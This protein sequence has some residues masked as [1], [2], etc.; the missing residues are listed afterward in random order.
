MDRT[1]SETRGLD[2]HFVPYRTRTNIPPMGTSGVRQVQEIFNQPDYLEQFIQGIAYHFRSLPANHPAAGRKTIL[3]GGDP[4][5]GNRERILKSAEILVANG[6]S[7]LMA[8]SG[9]IASTPAMSHAI[10]HKEALA[11]VIFTASHNPFTDVGIKVNLHDGSPALEDTA[12]SIHSYQNS[13]ENRGYYTVSRDEA[14][15]S[16]LLEEIPTVELYGDL[17]D[18]IFDF[19]SMR[20]AIRGRE[21][22]LRILLDGMGGAAGPYLKEVFSKRLELHPEYHRCEPDP[23]LGGASDPRRA[24]HP[25]PDFPYLSHLIEKN[26]TGEYD[27]VAAYDSDADRRL[28]GGSGFWIESADEFALFALHADLIQLEQHFLPSGE[29]SPEAEVV[30]ARSAVTSPAVDLM[31]EHLRRHYREKGLGLRILET[32]TGF[33]WIAEYGNW[34]VEESN[35]LGN[36]WIREKDGIFS[37][38]FL[39]KIMLQTGQTPRELM[40]EVWRRFGR[41]YFARGELSRAPER[42]ASD[43]A[44]QEELRS[45]EEQKERLQNLI[46]E[47]VREGKG[48]GEMFGTLQ[49]ESLDSWDYVDPTGALR[50]A[51]AATILQFGQGNRVKMRFSGTGSGGYTLRLYLTHYSREY[52]LSKRDLLS[53]VTDAL[54]HFFTWLGFRDA[55]PGS[56]NDEKQPEMEQGS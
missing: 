22:P 50:S 20:E 51:G 2:P 35:G 34:G 28:D 49:L 43:P 30:F 13:E 7:V 25:E 38:L 37:T 23:Y 36:P 26:A 5:L 44:Y 48:R 27:L 39:L 12:R 21:R 33:K 53:P 1:S 9:G 31:E 15:N 54:S 16:G 29:H 40:E 47:A 55:T 46:G 3:L 18:R 45:L 14:R 52:G 10:R 24:N 41:I 8:E 19:A 17:M 4:R 32:A 11:G 6:F 56:Y 42:S